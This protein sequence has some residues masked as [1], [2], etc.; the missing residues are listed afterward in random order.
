VSEKQLRKLTPQLYRAV[1]AESQGITDDVLPALARRREP[2]D[3]DKFIGSSELAEKVESFFKGAT[4]PQEIIEVKD[5]TEFS[6]PISSK[7]A[8]I[9]FSVIMLAATLLDVFLGSGIG[10]LSGVVYAIVLISLVYL[11]SIENA[12]DPILIGPL[13]Y[14]GAILISGQFNLSGV[15]SFLTQQVTMLLPTLAFNATWVVGATI[16]AAALTYLRVNGQKASE[17][18]Q[19]SD[20]YEVPEEAQR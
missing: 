9:L 17:L 19:P 10:A 13:I 6:L 8:A 2:V 7:F 16:I 20:L 11:V 18:S 14:F 5:H 4:A 15:G 12:W 3:Q 1:G